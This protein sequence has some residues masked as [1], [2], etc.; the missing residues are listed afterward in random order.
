MNFFFKKLSKLFYIIF[1][2]CLIIACGKKT[3]TIVPSNSTNIPLPMA[4]VVEEDG[5]E[6]TVFTFKY[7]TT[8]SQLEA[9]DYVNFGK[10]ILNFEHDSKGLLI[11]GTINNASLKLDYINNKITKATFIEDGKITQEREIFY[12]INNKIATINIFDIG[13][14]GIKAK[15][16]TTSIEL[17]YSG[18]NLSKITCTDEFFNNKKSTIFD[19]LAYDEKVLSETTGL[20]IYN[21]AIFIALCDEFMEIPLFNFQNFLSKN[22]IKTGRQ[23]FGLLGLAIVL[24]QNQVEPETVTQDLINKLNIPFSFSNTTKLIANKNLSINNVFKYINN[25]EAFT[26]NM[27]V[28]YTEK[29]GQIK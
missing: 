22:A 16:P 29:N 4:I 15:T 9:V 24:N 18:E 26:I 17:S 7:N 12:N 27:D 19:G 8:L 5:D 23:S 14:N 2:L 6:E 10:T 3:E 11:G 13:P 25:E 28:T 21:N 1:A 20:G